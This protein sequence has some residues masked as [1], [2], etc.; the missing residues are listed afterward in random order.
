MNRNP[1]IKITELQSDLA[2]FELSNTDISM[3]NS[4]RRIMIAEVPTLAIEFVE[5]EINT[6]ALQDEYLAHRL[7][8]I[9]LRS[10][11][12]MS[13]W[14]FA[15]ACDCDGYC[16]LCSVK[17]TLDVSG[18]DSSDTQDLDTSVT[19]R[20]LLTRNGQVQAVH[21]SNEEEEQAAGPGKY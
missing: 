6:S 10:F 16:D 9:P 8:L 4:L 19:S 2:C 17:F 18:P 12:P 15:H 21:F 13:E 1:K 3:A 7:G 20:D 14:C 5:F 11:R